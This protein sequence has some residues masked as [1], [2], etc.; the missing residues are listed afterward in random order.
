MNDY[1]GSN[2]S[3]RGEFPAQATL[4][5][6]NSFLQRVFSIMALGLAITGLTAF[7]VAQSQEMVYA[8]FGTPM[9][10]VIMFAPLAFILV[11]SFGIEKMSYAVATIVFASFSF[12]MGLSLSSIFLI[13]QMGSIASTFF[14][15]SGMFGAMAIFG[16]TTKRDLTKLGSILFMALIGILLATLVNFFI[17]STIM[18]LVISILGVIIFCG[19]T[20]YDMQRLKQMAGHASDSSD[21]SRKLAL[22]GALTLYLDFLNL[23]LFLLRLMGDRK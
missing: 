8:L 18:N 21:E 3:S 11:L 7:G 22:I 1:Y 19:F 17:K 9:R 14:V 2:S 16:Y 5:I 20:A 23:F 10:Y 6:T 15:S 12:V 13:Y 4:T